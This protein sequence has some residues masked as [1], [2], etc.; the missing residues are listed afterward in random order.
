[1]TRRLGLLLGTFF[2]AGYVPL[3]PGTLASAV[4]VALYLLLWPAGLSPLWLLPAAAVLFAPA[5]W[6]SGICEQ[7]FGKRDPGRVVV[8]E[9]LGQM[10]ALAAVPRGHVGVAGWKYWLLGFILFRLFDTLKPF[11]AGRSE[12]WPG[13]WGVVADDC[14][15]GVY[16][17]AG[18]RLAV[19]LGL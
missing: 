14:W 5:V 2:G 9:V 7:Q 12:Q 18:V 16:A 1:V 8:D 4:A 10:I 19:W 11:P 6:A 13:G 17:F 15:A 3:V